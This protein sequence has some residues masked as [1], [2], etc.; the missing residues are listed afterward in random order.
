VGALLVITGVGALL[1]ITGGINAP[2]YA[3]PRSF[4]TYKLIN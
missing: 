1:V 4:F 3:K 2:E